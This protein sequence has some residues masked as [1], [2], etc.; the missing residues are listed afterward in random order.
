MFDLKLIFAVI[1]SSLWIIAYFFYFKDIFGGKTKPHAYTWLVWSITQ[2]TAAA[3][4]WVGG[5]KFGAI[6]L[7]V[8]T[9]LVVVVFL[10]SFKY[11][12]KNITKGD[13][14]V[15]IGALSAI[16]VWWQLKNPFWAVAIVSVID[17]LGYIPTIRKS[18]SD[19]WSEALFFW[20]LMVCGNVLA[21]ASNAAYNFLTVAYLAT[22]TLA[23]VIL[24]S[25]CLI[26]RR[27]LT[28]AANLGKLI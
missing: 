1:A 19:P 26:R 27:K 15:L 6:N 23:D 3:A 16:V 9:V 28:G 17:G 21:L 4:I 8:G 14:L 13:T 12:T 11:G 25:V 18:F 2:G 7:A 20:I 22:L 24:I 5:G 10:L